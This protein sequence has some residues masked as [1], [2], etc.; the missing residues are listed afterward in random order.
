VNRIQVVEKLLPTDQDL[1]QNLRR[2][3][4]TLKENEN[5]THK[6]LKDIVVSRSNQGL[7]IRYVFEEP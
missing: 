5:L 3:Y 2:Q 7:E 1:L 4:L 6:V